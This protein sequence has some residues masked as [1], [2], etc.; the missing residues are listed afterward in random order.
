MAKLLPIERRVLE[1]ITEKGY[2]DVRYISRK[3]GIPVSDIS[4]VL[5][6]LAKKNILSELPQCG[7]EKCNYCPLR[8][9]CPIEGNKKG[10]VFVLKMEKQ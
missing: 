1:L 10:K 5:D 2:I 7:G 3:T 9:I 6:S 4:K 8:S